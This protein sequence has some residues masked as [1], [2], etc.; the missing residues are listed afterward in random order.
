MSPVTY[1]HCHAFSKPWPPP[2]AVP[3]CMI[4][5]WPC[6]LHRHPHPRPYYIC[7]ANQGMLPLRSSQFLCDHFFSD[8]LILLPV[9]TF[10]FLLPLHAGRRRG[11]MVGGTTGPLKRITHSSI[12]LLLIYS[13]LNGLHDYFGSYHSLIRYVLTATSGTD[14]RRPDIS[15]CSYTIS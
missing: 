15:I 13:L 5:S 12:L 2:K 1:Q 11:V 4:F 9:P 6:A 3:A 14:K 10:P 8:D 7:N